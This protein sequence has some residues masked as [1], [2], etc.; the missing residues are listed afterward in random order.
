DDQLERVASHVDDAD[1]AG[2]RQTEHRHPAD[3]ERGE[4]DHHRAPSTAPAGA[5][6]ASLAAAASCRNSSM[7]LATADG[8]STTIATSRR[9]SRLS[10]AS[11][12]LPTTTLAPSTS[13]I[14]PCA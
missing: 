9:K 8:S 4:V 2:V 5:V 11:A 7:A 10:A 13:M 3:G 1:S 12:R 6:P 14:L